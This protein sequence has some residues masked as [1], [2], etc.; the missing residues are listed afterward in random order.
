MPAGRTTCYRADIEARPFYGR[1]V[2]NLYVRFV[3]FSNAAGTA[4]YDIVAY[5]V[6][7]EFYSFYRSLEAYK[8]SMRGRGAIRFCAK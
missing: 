7:P 6:N 2:S 4:P 5:G 8:A 3:S 1:E